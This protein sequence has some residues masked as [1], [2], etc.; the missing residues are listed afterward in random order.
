VVAEQAILFGRNVASNLPDRIFWG[1]V[2]PNIVGNP[3]VNQVATDIFDIASSS[4]QEIIDTSHEHTPE[5]AVEAYANR[6]N[7]FKR[8]KNAAYLG[9]LGV[10]TIADDALTAPAW[11]GM[12]DTIQ[13]SQLPSLVQQAL[14][15]GGL[16]ALSTSMAVGMSVL[17]RRF[18]KQNFPH[19]IAKQDPQ[20]AKD[21]E[22]TYAIGVPLRVHLGEIKNS[23]DIV[24]HSLAYATVGQ[25]VLYQTLD[26]LGR[27]AGAGES[28]AMFY[29]GLLA[30]IA[31]KY[32]EDLYPKHWSV[33]TFKAIVNPMRLIASAKDKVN[34]RIDT[35]KLQFA[36][37]TQPPWPA[38]TTPAMGLEE[39]T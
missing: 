18:R 23:F 3:V 15:G 5:E 21:Y 22:L 20:K 38:P 25:F 30:F 24:K 10:Y 12:N 29:T 26:K 35:K 39:I 7:I 28:N 37:P 32:T 34:Q 9:A 2:A 33:E 19:D 17:A 13:D 31:A 4:R 16:I 27:V 14:S 1:A 6:W 8:A 11:Q 36:Q